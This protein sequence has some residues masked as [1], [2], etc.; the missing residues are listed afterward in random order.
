MALRMGRI[1]K[2]RNESVVMLLM[3][4]V[5]KYVTVVII[6]CCPHGHMCHWRTSL[7]SHLSVYCLCVYMSI[8]LCKGL[9]NWD[10]VHCPDLLCCQFIS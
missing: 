5:G 3:V 10:V 7:C 2:G 8:L 6:R 4:V 1:S 9:E